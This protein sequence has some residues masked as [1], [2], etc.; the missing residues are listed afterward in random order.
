MISNDIKNRLKWLKELYEYILN[1]V[2]GDI[3]LAKIIYKRVVF[4]EN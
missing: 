4:E 1:D 3:E 2:G